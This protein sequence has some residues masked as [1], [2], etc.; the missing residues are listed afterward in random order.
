MQFNVFRQFEYPKPVQH[1]LGVGRSGAVNQLEETG[2]LPIDLFNECIMTVFVEQT[3][4]LPRY[5]NY[6]VYLKL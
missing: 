2:L 3:L 5:A 6:H 4:D 1:C